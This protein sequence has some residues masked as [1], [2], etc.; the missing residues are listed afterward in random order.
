MIAKIMNLYVYVYPYNYTTNYV[1]FFCL[2][3][4]IHP[5]VLQYKKQITLDSHDPLNNYM[6]KF[7]M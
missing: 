7:N 2:N 1:S 3:Y 5:H 6:A 4:F